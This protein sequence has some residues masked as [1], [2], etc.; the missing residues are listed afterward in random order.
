M[1]EEDKELTL[2][3]PLSPLNGL[4]SPCPKLR[5]GSGRLKLFLKTYSAS[6]FLK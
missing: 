1:C 3:K 4:S 2:K 6:S 5:S